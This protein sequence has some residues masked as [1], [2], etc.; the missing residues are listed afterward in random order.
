MKR[1]MKMKDPVL[2]DEAKYDRE[3]QKAENERRDAIETE[4]DT[5]WDEVGE[6]DHDSELASSGHVDQSNAMAVARREALAATQVFPVR[7]D[8][9]AV[10]DLRLQIEDYVKD[11]AERRVDS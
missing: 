9:G 1:R 10:T 11:V 2:T 6:G 8:M 7:K 5:V 3:C 4:M